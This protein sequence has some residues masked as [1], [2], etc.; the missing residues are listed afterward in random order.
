[1][2]RLPSDLLALTA[3]LVAAALAGCEA[4]SA[5]AR[6]ASPA[7]AVGTLSGVDPS[8]L[9][10]LEWRSVGPHRGGRSI[11]VVGDPKDPLV[12]YFGS[13]H[14]GVWKTE[15]AGTYWRNV[16]DGFFKKSP[17]GAIDVR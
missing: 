15:D 4:E 7:P 1:M 6:S 9:S 2:K 13:T 17:V 16:S 14:G 12:F 5:P 8:V 11:A 3:L 10:A